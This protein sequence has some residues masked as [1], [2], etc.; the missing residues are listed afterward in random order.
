MGVLKQFAIDQKDSFPITVDIIL[1]DV[2]LD[3]IFTGCS[4]LKELEILKSEL[5]QLF[6]SAGMSL[7]KWCFSH[8]NSDLSDLQFDQLSKEDNVKTL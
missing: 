2:Y 8:S 4:N 7:H 3:D 6:E 1:Q 5:V